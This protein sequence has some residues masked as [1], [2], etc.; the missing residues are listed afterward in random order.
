MMADATNPVATKIKTIVKRIFPRR[1]R[2]FMPATVEAIEK[3]T[4]GTMAEKSKFR[5]ISPSGL[6]M[7]ASF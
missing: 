1:L 7:T 2:S 5:S 6:N 3:K 4:S